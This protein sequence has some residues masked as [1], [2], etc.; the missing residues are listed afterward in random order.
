[1]K[2]DVCSD[3]HVDSWNQTLGK[4]G[5]LDWADYKHTDSTVLII[6]GDI[7]NSWVQS[8]TVV[9]NARKLYDQVIWVDGNHE[10]Y[11]SGAQTVVG[12]EANLAT[13]EGFLP[14]QQKID[15][16]PVEIIGVNGWYDW[17]ISDKVDTQR[18]MNAWAA[19]MNDSRL[20]FDTFNH[21]GELATRDADAL[22]KRLEAATKPVVVVTHTVPLREFL[23]YTGNFGWDSLTPSFGNSMF[24]QIAIDHKDKIICWIFG[25]THR[26][27]DKVVYGIRF[28]N[29]AR[30]YP[31]ELAEPWKLTQI[32]V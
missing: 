7:S 9:E 26:R 32:E 12:V 15:C 28:I 23:P 22:R 24:E 31:L 10:F 1:M 20:D 25:H 6:A 19:G 14:T 3:L 4:L 11:F 2:I 18:A 16:G 29:N 30:A 8:R 21:P 27:S 5:N 17:K 13:V